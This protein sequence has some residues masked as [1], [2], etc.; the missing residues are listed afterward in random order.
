MPRICTNGHEFKHR[1]FRNYYPKKLVHLD[2]I[3]KVKTKAILIFKT[4]FNLFESNKHKFI[5]SVGLSGFVWFF[6]FTFGVFDFDYFTYFA[7]LYYTGTYSLACLAVLLA[8]FFLL[9]DYLIK[10]KTIADA[11]VWVLWIMSC[12]ALS[13][14]LLTTLFFKWEE[15]TLYNFI[16]N[17]LYVSSIGMIVAPIFILVNY[18]FILRK[19]ICKTVNKNIKN[20][21]LNTIQKSN[22]LI[23]IYSKYKNGAFEIDINNLLYIQSSDNYIDI[24]Y[25]NKDSV[26]HELVRN[27]LAA[28]EQSITHPALQRCHRSFIINKNHVK[29]LKRNAGRYKIIMK[30]ANIEIPLSRKYK[31]DVF[32]SMGKKV[33]VRP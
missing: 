16:K 5:I 13:N 2:Q 3:K 1:T 29:S 28:V 15:F 8:D 32:L 20:N 6:L 19:R 31:V 30:N 24:W 11:L 23:T 10:K 26:Q 21:Q 27:T 7:R 25:T 9:K 4:P 12:I 17:Q 33:V 18:I 14:Y 22:E